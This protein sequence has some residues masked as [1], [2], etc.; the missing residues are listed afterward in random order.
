MDSISV[1]YWIR[2]S[3]AYTIDYGQLAAAG[4]VRA[5]RIVA[6]ELAIPHQVICVNCS[7]VG[8]GD[9][10]GSS[11]DPRAP[12]SE[13]WPFRNQLLL[14]L[15]GA[16]A[17]VD[18]VGELI[19]GAVSSDCSHADGRAEF[20]AAADALFA[21]QEGNIRVSAPAIRMTAAEL[22]QSSGIPRS[23][24][25]WAHSCH[26]SNHACGICRGC[27]KHSE[28]MINLGAHDY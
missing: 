25:A 27:I 13:W 20:F 4:E 10:A 24:L 28:T 21:L 11:P 6:A 1:A 7:S 2:P 5:A 18:G 19:F 16:R 14:T 23:L 8:S 12:V 3:I 22:V 9:M 17:L 26:V 15:A